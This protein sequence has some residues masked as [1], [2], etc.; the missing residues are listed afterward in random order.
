MLCRWPYSHAHT[1]AGSNG[2]ESGVKGP[3]QMDLIKAHCADVQNALTIN[4][5]KRISFENFK[6]R[7]S[8]LQRK[9][10]RANLPAGALSH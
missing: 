1:H 7:V 2:G 3:W 4:K 5:Q 9:K 10:L 8:A 6:F